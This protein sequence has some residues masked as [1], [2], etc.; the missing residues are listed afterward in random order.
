MTMNH[1]KIYCEIITSPSVVSRAT[2]VSLIVGTLLNII[3]Q[4]DAIIVLDFANIN[5]SKL[6]LTYLVP[7]SV[8]T[9]TA[10]AMKLEFQIGTKAV[11]EA[12]LQCSICGNEIHVQK[13]ELILECPKCGI[14]TH[15]Q[16]K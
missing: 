11:I 4:G 1:F 2:K 9:Y 14:N 3:N 8:T 12:D 16:L 7:F 15:W 5:I 6:L 13:D 10:T